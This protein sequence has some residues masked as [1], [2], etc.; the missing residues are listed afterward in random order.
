MNRN[1]GRI[2]RVLVGIAAVGAVLAAVVWNPGAGLLIALSLAAMLAIALVAGF[3]M[4]S[5]IRWLP[6]AS[7]AASLLCV[8]GGRRIFHS[9]ID[10]GRM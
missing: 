4:E 9:M 5:P 6:A 8:C 2:M 1:E 3:A 7:V 10:R